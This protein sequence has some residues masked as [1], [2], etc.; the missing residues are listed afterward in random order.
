[1]CMIILEI[2]FHAGLN[3]T[4]LLVFISICE[5]LS[6]VLCVPNLLLL[7]LF[8]F[9]NNLELWSPKK[10]VSDSFYITAFTDLE[11]ILLRFAGLFFEHIISEYF[12][13]N[14]KE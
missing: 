13:N 6:Y 14:C 12:R 11:I 8:F 10:K 9:L 2:G 7:N 1:M 4:L 3:P 5:K